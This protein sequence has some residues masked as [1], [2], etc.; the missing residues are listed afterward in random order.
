[1]PNGTRKLALLGAPLAALLVLG[2]GG[3]AGLLASL[4]RS[5]GEVRVP[6]LIANVTIE[7]DRHAVPRVRSGSLDD[8]FRALGFLH[9]QQR[10]FQ[11]DLA[12]RS[13][14]G[15]LAALLGAR[16][17]PLDRAQRPQDLRRRADALLE[18][19]P[20][21]HR[22]W[23]EA[24]AAGVNAGLEDLGTRPPE[25]WLLRATP[26]QWAP[27]DSVLVLLA[28]YTRL[29]NNEAYER[30]QA[31]MHAV[32]PPD[33]YAFLTPSATRFD[34]PLLAGANDP[35]GGYAPLPVPTPTTIDLRGAPTLP[36]VEQRVSPP[37]TGPA[38]NQWAATGARTHDGTAL[39]ANDPHLD[40]SLPA[41]FYRA[42]LYWPGGVARGLTIPGLPGVVLGA[43]AEVAWGATVS[44]ADQSDWVL[45]EAVPGDPSRYRT[46][47]GDEPFALVEHR[48]GVANGEPVT[49]EA[50][51]TRW[52]PVLSEDGLGRPLALRATWLDPDGADL[53]LLELMTARNV[54]DAVQ[55]TG[56]WSGPS[57]NWAFADRDGRIAWTVNGP[58]PRRLGFD[59][60]RP[61]PWSAD[62]VGWNGRQTLPVSFGR[63]DGIVFN[64]NNRS[65]PEPQASE[66]SRAWMRPLRAKRIEELLGAAERFD[67]PAFLAMQLDTRAEGYDLL[68]DVILEVVPERGAQ[69]L[70]ARAR[71]HVAGWNG[72]ADAGEP[73]FRILQI[74]YRAL[75]GGA[76]GPL[77]APAVAADPAFVY[78][79][80]LADEP[81]RRLLEE[82]PAHL[83]PGGYASWQEFLAGVLYEA[84][85]ALERDPGRPG[86]DAPWGEVNR[87]NVGH[88]LAGAPIVGRWLELPSAP[89]AGSTLSLRRASPSYG[90]V[91]RM[92]IAPAR[93]EA[94]ILQMFGGQS[95]HFLSRNF[96]DLTD[97]WLQGAPTPFLAGSTANAYRLVPA[98]DGS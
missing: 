5:A 48:I 88:V 85:A 16:A 8:A 20:A 96:A 12:R 57:L 92:V 32:L 7:L 28:F 72:H 95:G 51:V 38:S 70:L 47:D 27:L 90:S 55:I 69:P 68:R 39:L 71:A 18:R 78:R 44:N 3:Y 86:I 46:P 36:G 60:S 54:G 67:E 93:P 84:L 97:D 62:G 56:E 87:L 74:Y 52:G 37:E 98:D 33:V 76:L 59:G 82:R 13:A 83:L 49:L 64:A 17:L 80:P 2:A 1:M 89:L 65:L 25:Y 77:L 31:V 6:G 24:Y 14:A 9:A 21:H 11:M 35:T 91:F 42:E 43:T 29:S 26:E 41:S 94:G 50:R 23:L 40:L 58:L 10:F 66:L 4:P 61:V 63:A 73:G 34:R 79:W 75:L 45:V 81:L 15:E 19:W 53:G 22:V 30:P